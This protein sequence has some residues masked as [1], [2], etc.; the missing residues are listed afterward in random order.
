MAN[1]GMTIFAGRDISARK[2]FH[3]RHSRIRHF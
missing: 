2:A 1:D 3:I